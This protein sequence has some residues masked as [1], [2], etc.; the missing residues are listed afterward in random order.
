MIAQ[1]LSRR[2]FL[3]GLGVTIALP[4]L[5]AMLPRAASAAAMPRPPVCT[6]FLYA[7]NGVNMADWTPAQ[8]GA[9][10]QLPYIIEPLQA[11]KNDVLVLTGL[12]QD[13]GRANGDSC[14]ACAYSNNISWRS[15]TT[16]SGAEINPR[17]VFGRLFAANATLEKTISPP[18]SVGGHEY[19][20]LS[21][22]AVEGNLNDIAASSPPRRSTLT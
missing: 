14:Y 11:H 4:F 5:E 1:P 20:R 13:K 2:T 8:T 21:Q 15:D 7:P 9:D 18:H 10:F 12:A 3:H 22:F 19:A 16:P 17:L 6:A